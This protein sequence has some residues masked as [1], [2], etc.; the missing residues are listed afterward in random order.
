MKK[1]APGEQMVYAVVPVPPRPIQVL[2]RG[3]VEQPGP[4][5]EP[6]SLSCLPGLVFDLDSSKVA[7]EGAR[8]V[9]LADWISSPANMLTWRSIVNRVW[10]YHFGRGIVDTPNDFGRNGAQPTHPEL[11]DWL[12]TEFRDGGQSLKSLHALIVRSA[13]YRQSS[14]AEPAALKVDADNRFL[15]RMNRTRL[16]AE[17]LRDSVLATSG[18]LDTR[19]GGPGFELF[20]FKD[21]HSPVYDH[22]DPQVIDSPRVWRRTVYRFIVRSVPNPFLDCLDSADPNLSTPTRTTTITPLQSLALWNDPFMI[23]QSQYFARRLISQ[24]VD[25]RQQ[26]ED[27]FVITLGRPSRKAEAEAVGDYAAAHGLANAC[28]VLYNTSEFVFID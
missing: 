28:R 22:T 6:G 13:V 20:R 11:L 17:E 26:I 24:T 25:P 5:V 19:M 15:W 9:A 18:M 23:R 8:R 12:A 16:D 7:G 3:E 1:A 10:H 21:D 14:R 4:A 2:A 27:A